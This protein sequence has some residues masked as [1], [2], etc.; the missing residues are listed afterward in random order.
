M[1]VTHAKDLEDGGAIYT[2]EYSDDSE[3]RALADIG[4]KVAVACAVSGMSVDDLI[5]MCA[6]KT[7]ADQLQID[8]E[9]RDAA[10]RMGDTDS[11]D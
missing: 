4:I 3:I 5:V 9:V 7:K 11:G 1:Q 6:E 10:E 2:V 8:E